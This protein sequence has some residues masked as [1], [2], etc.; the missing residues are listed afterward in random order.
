MRETYSPDRLRFEAIMV[1]D[2][3]RLPRGGL[4]LVPHS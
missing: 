4:P 2:E 3:R 1:Y